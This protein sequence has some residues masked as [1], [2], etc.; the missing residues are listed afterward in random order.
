[1]RTM[2]WKWNFLD[3]CFYIVLCVVVMFGLT[4][5]CILSMHVGVCVCECVCKR[6]RFDWC[7]KS[8]KCIFHCI[9]CIAFLAL[10]FFPYSFSGIQH[11]TF[12]WIEA[13]NFDF[14]FKVQVQLMMLITWESLCRRWIFELETKIVEFFR[15]EAIWIAL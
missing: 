11:H 7:W 5:Q 4:L 15:W 3:A 1:M 6:L 2:H 12:E 10:R 13:L 8:S 14:S 9:L